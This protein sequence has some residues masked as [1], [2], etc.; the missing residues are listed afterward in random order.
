IF[1]RDT[2]IPIVDKNGNKIST[3]T[4]NQ[5]AFDVTISIDRNWLVGSHSIEALD[6]SSSQN[7]F[8]TIQVLPAGT[9]A[10]SSTELSVSRQGKPASLL[11][12]TAVIGQGNP[13]PQQITITNTS[14]SPLNWTATAIA[15]NNLNWLMINDNNN[16]GRLAI[17][18]PHSILISVN[19][20]G[21]KIT[22]TNHPY[23]GRIIFTSNNSQ[24][25]TLPVQLQIV[26]AKPEMVFSP[27]PIIAPIGPGNTCQA[28]VTLTLINLGT[29]AI[30]WAVNPDLTDKIKFVSNGQPLES[31]TLLPS[32]SLLPSGQ[33][34]DTV[35]LTLQC[36][37]IQRGQSYHV[38]VY[39]NKLS[40]SEL[41]TIQ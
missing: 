8:Q 1:L 37:N 38:S 21:L 7:A 11:T 35:V 39:A 25:L 19:T 2:A 20:V 4:D 27:N 29:A 5:G 9:A 14:N 24:L 10:I 31:G 40:W 32:G 30:S 41:V 28:G 26:N 15:N 33:P 16:Y 6:K 36:T 22:D 17:S 13:D 23:V 3:Q 12:F 18:Q 34:G